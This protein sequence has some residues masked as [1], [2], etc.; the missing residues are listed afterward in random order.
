V[1]GDGCATFG[2]QGLWTAARHAVPVAFVV[3]DNGEYRT[4]KDTL[5][6]QKSRSTARGRYVGLD[7]REPALDWLAVGQAFGVP[8]TRVGS[9]DEL[10]DLVASAGRLGGPLL[11][12]VPISE[13]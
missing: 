9:A 8:A 4:L 1:V 13:R 12:D 10:R 11:V 5:D 3:L 7:L 6:R 2:M